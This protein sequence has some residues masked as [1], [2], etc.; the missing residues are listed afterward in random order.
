MTTKSEDKIY[1]GKLMKIGMK[2]SFEKG[3]KLAQK[4]VILKH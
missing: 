1:S 2:K 4:V 3:Y